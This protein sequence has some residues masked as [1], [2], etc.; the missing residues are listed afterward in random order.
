MCKSCVSFSFWHFLSPGNWTCTQPNE[1]EN[2][3]GILIREIL[4]KRNLGRLFWFKSPEIKRQRCALQY[5]K[6]HFQ[7]QSYVLPGH[8]QMIPRKCSSNKVFIA[9]IPSEW[10]CPTYTALWFMEVARSLLVNSAV[11]EQEKT[12]HLPVANETE[13]GQNHQSELQRKTA[14]G[15]CS[16]QEDA[17]YLCSSLRL[18]MRQGYNQL[19]HWV[20]PTYFNFS[21]WKAVSSLH[22][23]ASSRPS[24]IISMFWE[25]CEGLTQRFGT[26][27]RATRQMMI[28][29]K[30][31]SG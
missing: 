10:V 30:T 22:G 29:N 25:P 20:Y 2:E 1:R 5:S 7:K 24:H 18:W 26:L 27:G 23:N 14:L 21:L 3:T 13:T 8:L 28:H 11:P 15:V 4:N 31:A 19:Q 17:K 12:N 16:G 9:L 6:I